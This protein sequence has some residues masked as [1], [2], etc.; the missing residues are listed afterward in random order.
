MRLTE[1]YLMKAEL[2]QKTGTSFAQAM[3][4]INYIRNR[5]ELGNL[6]VGNKTDFEKVLFSEIL[7]EL[8]LENEADWMASLRLK[9]VAGSFMLQDFRGAATVLDQNKFIWPIPTS[10]MKFNKLIDQNPGYENLNY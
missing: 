9:N 5:S 6:S 10:E 4:P 1:L 7:N 8:N 2:L 3:D